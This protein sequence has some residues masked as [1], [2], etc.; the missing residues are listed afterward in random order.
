MSPMPRS[1]IYR[2]ATVMHITYRVD[3]ALMVA[4]AAGAFD[5]EEPSEL[6]LSV[7]GVAGTATGGVQTLSKTVLVDTRTPF[8]KRA[9]KD[10]RALEPAGG[11]PYFD[12][13]APLHE[14]RT[15]GEDPYTYV[16]TIV[17]QEFSYNQPSLEQ[18][19]TWSAKIP[20]EYAP[21]DPRLILH[22][23][24]EVHQG[25]VPADDVQRALRPDQP[26]LRTRLEDGRPND[27]TLLMMGFVEPYTHGIG[28]AGSFIT[29]RGKDMVGIFEGTEA[30]IEAIS[31]INFDRPFNVV[32]AEV[33][34]TIG[35]DFGLQ[36]DVEI[37]TDEWAGVVPHLVDAE[38]VTEIRKRSSEG[39]SDKP[40]L[41]TLIIRY[42]RMVG[43]TPFFRGRVLHIRRNRR[44]Y[45]VIKET[46]EPS[47]LATYS[48][49]T[50]DGERYPVRTFVVGNNVDSIKVERNLAPKRAPIIEVWG[51][52]DTLRGDA[53]F[54]K[55]QW[56]P[57][58]AKAARA[59]T[60]GQVQQVPMPGITDRENLRGLAQ[61]IYEK[62]TRGVLG[63]TI[64]TKNLASFG[65][66][67]STPDVL[68][69]RI[70]D[71]VQLLVSRAARLAPIDFSV[72]DDHGIP[73]SEAVSRVA[74]SLRYNASTTRDVWRQRRGQVGIALEI[75]SG[76][77]AIAQL[78]VISHRSL[79]PELLRY[80]KVTSINRRWNADNGLTVSF[81]FQNYVVSRHGAQEQ[82]ERD[83]RAVRAFADA[84]RIR[85]GRA[86][87]YGHN[88]Q[89]ADQPRIRIGTATGYGHK[90]ERI[91]VNVDG[92][93]ASE[94]VDE[95]DHP[96]DAGGQGTD[97]IRDDR[98]A[99]EA[100]GLGDWMN[101]EYTTLE[102][103]E[104]DPSLS[105]AQ[106]RLKI[107]RILAADEQ[108]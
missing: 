22:A 69:M 90:T 42:C 44:L 57:K 63:G 50:V 88:T 86:T 27:E 14:L 46:R 13:F 60:S 4:R 10:L 18:S 62:Q 87:G 33:L 51:I 79:I 77:R 64:Q 96:G 5:Y 82:K 43:A 19:G 45:D 97:E 7:G 74:A 107:N 76:V 20:Y 41:W 47:S 68:S 28:S 17:P 93:W 21:F 66:E 3:A 54:I 89:P 99:L 108:R 31:E 101:D 59:I 95:L 49:R 92:E 104:N 73:Y 84:N 78:I 65:G 52:D 72:I 98:Q 24:V 80:F 36:M 55:E 11:D 6:T 39:A 70:G 53:R 38:G 15:P 12:Y 34:E 26:V 61:D 40:S 16:C 71:T 94:A 2:P 103:V 8:Q 37:D 81:G 48:P 106:R 67:N 25:T 58:D 100:A 29:M 32:L 9:A 85:I 83:A 91:P 105:P 35:L 75:D 56:P 102:D 30:N 23:M 1:R